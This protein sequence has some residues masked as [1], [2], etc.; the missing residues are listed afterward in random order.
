[1]RQRGGDLL[2]GDLSCFDLA[3]T[4][5]CGQAFRWE[6]RDGAWRGVACGRALCLRQTG[7]GGLVFQN[8][9]RATFDAVWRRYFDL[10]R[11]YA[12]ILAGYDD[13]ALRRA[14]DTCGGIRILRQEPWE[15]LASFLLSSNNN[16]PRIR[17]IIGRLCAT[18]GDPL[19]DGV[20]A[21]PTAERL[22]PLDEA[23]LAPLRAGYRAAYLLDAA[24]RVAGGALDLNAVDAL[25]FDEAEAALR[26]VVG[27]GPKVAQCVL[28]YG[29]GRLQAFPEDVWIRRVMRELYPS[30]LPACIRGTEGIAQQYLFDY[31][32]RTAP[33]GE[34][35]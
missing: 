6:Q 19:G 20:Y 26:T 8:T 14:V 23:A 28:L 24:R 12:A 16:I 5:D 15:T 4:L 22:A 25:P 30:G 29:F 9:D 18:F 32:R 1:M 34:R 33:K 21:F 11:D 27:V 35:L 3:R 10:D 13:P 31:A 7:G 17:A 2:V